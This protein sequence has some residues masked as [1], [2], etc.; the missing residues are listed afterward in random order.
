MAWRIWSLA[1]KAVLPVGIPMAAVTAFL[2]YDDRVSETRYNEPHK[3]VIPPHTPPPRTRQELFKSLAETAE[4]DI[5]VIGGGAT[6]TGVA[7]DSITRGYKTALVERE[8]FASAT[9]SRSTKLV[10]G[11]VRY[12]E[13]A[14]WQADYGQYLLVKEALAERRTFLNMAPHLSFPLPIMIPVYKWW[15]LPYYYIGVKMYDLIAG[16]ANL[17]PSYLV[18]R[19]RALRLFPMLNENKL[20]GAIVYYDG[21]Q[22]DARMNSSLAVSAIE[23]GA[24]ILNYCEVTGLVKNEQGKTCGAEVTDLETGDKYTVKSKV[25]VN[26]TG[27][28]TDSI[29][30]MD[31][32]KAL[33]I[34]V[35]SAGVH[36]VLPGWYAPANIG[37][38]DAATSDGR[39]VFF[40]PWQGST[41]AGTTDRN[42]KIET[43]PAPNE[44]DIQ[45]IL[46]EVKHYID[47]KLDCKREDVRAAWAGIRPLVKDPHSGGGTQ[48]MVRSHTVLVSD[49]DLVTIAGGKWTTFREMAEETVDKAVEIAGLPKRECVTRTT[50]LVGAE[51]WNQLTYT[52]LIRE[53][54]IAAR[55]ARHL[56]ENYGTRSFDVARL[57]T[58][59]AIAPDGRVVERNARLNPTYPILDGEVLYAMAY[60]YARTPIDVLARR[61]RLA[62]LDA[63][64]AR[65]ALSGI[66]EVMSHRFN[67]SLERQGMEFTRSMQWLQSMGLPDHRPINA[68]ISVSPVTHAVFDEPSQTP[69]E[70]IIQAKLAATQPEDEINHEV[71]VAPEGG[72]KPIPSKEAAPAPK[73]SREKS[74]AAN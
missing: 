23:R 44:E 49:S 59:T 11:G 74:A 61:T 45:F 30:K 21:S 15:Q 28:F 32:Q 34:A 68:D 51:G 35:G 63:E 46:D 5:L 69:V 58:P 50:P 55:S 2:I 20:K 31:N 38:L 29:R 19:T 42:C 41:I 36:I 48:N 62:F 8:D 1:R 72:S 56:S 9:S 47:G 73:E 7:W 71:S 16:S 3:T 4:Y 27:P 22:N 54:G 13:K 64:A 53:F 67:W 43:N 18:S 37:L 12:L 40:L 10:H 57:C 14:F 60:E 17:E 6:G 39:V 70:E 33:N 24:D 65:D 52:D 66:I 26:A 25:V